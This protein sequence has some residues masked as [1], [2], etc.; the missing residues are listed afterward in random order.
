MK[1]FFLILIWSICIV[2]TAYSQC[3][4]GDLI[5][6]TNSLQEGIYKTEATIVSAGSIK[7]KA[8]FLAADRI[9]LKSGFS[10]AAG[11]TFKANNMG[12]NYLQEYMKEAIIDLYP[13]LKINMPNYYTTSGIVDAGGDEGGWFINVSNILANSDVHFSASEVGGSPYI[14][15]ALSEPLPAILEHYNQIYDQ[16]EMIYSTSENGQINGVLYYKTVTGQDWDREAYYLH[17]SKN[18]YMETYY[19]ETLFI[20][21]ASAKHNEV[22]SILETISS[23]TEY[24]FAEINWEGTLPIDSCSYTLSARND[25]FA[26][27]NPE[28]IETLYSTNLPNLVFISYKSSTGPTILCDSYRRPMVIQ[29]ITNLSAC[30]SQN[31]NSSFIAQENTLYCFPDGQYFFIESINNQFCPY[32]IVDCFSHGQLSLTIQAL[33]SNGNIFRFIHQPTFPPDF[34]PFLPDGWTIS[35]PVSGNESGCDYIIEV[36]MTI[37]Q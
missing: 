37:N 11:E 24:A 15:A 17:L 12:C 32:C 23:C 1:M 13:C 10:V 14:P 35:T 25:E 21:Y 3:E 5:Y 6:S 29:S 22:I 9:T 28:M 36:E 31:Y 30:T 26:P 7:N 27:S 34:P 4:T 18:F 19:L 33:D 2:A 8:K 16:R 20:K